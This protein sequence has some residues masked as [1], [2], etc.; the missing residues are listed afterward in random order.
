MLARLTHLYFLMRTRKFDCKFQ[1]LMFV[2]QFDT[3]IACVPFLRQIR[4]QTPS[5]VQNSL[6]YF[7]LAA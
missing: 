2:K 6:Q 3:I 4:R 5:F 7:S 1:L